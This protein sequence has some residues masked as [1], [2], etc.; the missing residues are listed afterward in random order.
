MPSPNWGP[1]EAAVPADQLGEWMW[2]GRVEHDGR[3]I[4]QYKHHG[5]RRY[6]S[7]DEYGQGWRVWYTDS[8][9]P[10]EFEKVLLAD[11]IRQARR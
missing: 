4:E 9:T 3:T 2:M 10:P 1:L 5:S 8:S 6:A 11:A 7:I